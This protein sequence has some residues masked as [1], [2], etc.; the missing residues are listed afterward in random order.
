MKQA[1]WRD[2]PPNEVRVGGVSTNL[3]KNRL[4]ESKCEACVLKH[5]FL[6]LCSFKISKRSFDVVDLPLVPVIVIIF[7]W[8]KL[9]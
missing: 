5:G 6:F 7:D 2:L 9:Q 8:G 4:L 3:A 1:L